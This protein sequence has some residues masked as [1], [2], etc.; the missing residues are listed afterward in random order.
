MESLEHYKQ[1][2][3]KKLT[4]QIS[5]SDDGELWAKIKE[6]PH[7]YTQADCFPKL[8]EMINDVVFL[9]FDVPASYKSKLGYYVPKEWVN[10]VMRQKWQKFIKEMLIENK[11]EVSKTFALSEV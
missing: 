4:I 10:E 9:H 3:P 7:C 6:L 8:I 2:L 5:K 1:L 11:K